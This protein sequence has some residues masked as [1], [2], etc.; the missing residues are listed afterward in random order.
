MFRDTTRLLKKNLPTP[1]KRSRNVPVLDDDKECRD[2][3]LSCVSGSIA[4]I[5]HVW[6][7]YPV[8]QRIGKQLDKAVIATA[9]L[10]G[11]SVSAFIVSRE[12]S[13]PITPDFVSP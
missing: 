11:S 12:P 2:M 6:T 7:V 8:P 9:G 1:A 10:V 5:R 3:Q 13:A 4:L